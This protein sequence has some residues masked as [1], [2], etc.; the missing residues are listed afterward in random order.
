M[1]KN[2]KQFMIQ[3]GVYDPGIFKA[4]FLAGGPGS[5]K[6]FV[7]QS[8]FAGV[9]LKFVNS[10]NIFTSYLKKHGLSLKMPENEK[11]MRNALR[12]RAKAKTQARQDMWV[13]GKLGLIIDGTGRDYVK[14]STQARFLKTI[15][16][17][18][19]HMIY[20]NTSLDVAL[21]RNISRSKQGDRLVPEYILK[22]NWNTVHANIGKFQSLFAGNFHI[23]D[24]NKSEKELVTLT[25]KKAAA[26]ARRVMK[27]PHGWQAR[28]WIQ[29]ELELKKKK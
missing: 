18:D 1:K 17:Y 9:G 2:F 6:T 29:K 16:G 24:N 27:A 28:N 20:I 23:I 7:S 21:E 8:A 13:Q 3:E 15:H 26:L 10:D 11:E 19:I 22:K 25:L 14:I 5:G 4:V 12:I